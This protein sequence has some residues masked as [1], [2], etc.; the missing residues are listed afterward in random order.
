SLNHPNIITI[1]EIGRAGSTH[2]IATELVEGQ[3]LRQQM[4]LGRLR[5]SAALD[6]AAQVAS[7]LAAAHAAGIAH[8]D[9][10]PENIMMRP[11]GLVKVLDFGLAKLIERQGPAP[12]DGPL[13]AE[14]GGTLPG[15]VLGTVGYMSPEQVRAAKVDARTDIFS[16]GVVLYEVL[17]GRQPFR[18]DS[19]VEVMNAILKEDPAELAAGN[20][21]RSSREQISPALER[22]VRRCLE[23]RP[24][25][26]FQSASDLA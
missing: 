22:V 15:M 14:I 11:D 24:E 17:A 21:P 26:R 7:A 16:L 23:K 8:R 3:T 5:L 25:A 20:E 1:Y 12:G 18:G 13:A 2:F 19:A 6:T 10:K 9:I 4:A